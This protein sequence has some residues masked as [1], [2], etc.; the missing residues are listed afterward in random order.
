MGYFG[1]IFL[2]NSSVNFLDRNSLIFLLFL[3]FFT[4][5]NTLTQVHVLKEDEVTWCQ[6][7]PGGSELDKA[8]VMSSLCLAT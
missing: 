6:N 3:V 7:L 8:E 5:T 1:G 2:L 4:P